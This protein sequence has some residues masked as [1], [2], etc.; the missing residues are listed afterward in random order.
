M[1][2]NRPA[3]RPAPSAPKYLWKGLVVWPDFMS[4]ECHHYIREDPRALADLAEE[5]GT[6]DLSPGSVWEIAGAHA[7]NVTRVFLRSEWYD[8]AGL[9]VPDAVAAHGSSA[10]HYFRRSQWAFPTLEGFKAC[11]NYAED[12]ARR[13]DAR[14]FL[15]PPEVFERFQDDRRGPAMLSSQQD[16]AWTHLRA[17]WRRHRTRFEAIADRHAERL[18]YFR[19]PRKTLTDVWARGPVRVPAGVPRHSCAKH[20]EHLATLVETSSR[21]GERVL[22][23]FGGSAP[24]LRA[25]AMLARSCDTIEQDPAWHRHAARIIGGEAILTDAT[26]QQPGL[27]F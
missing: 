13:L 27:P 15:V 21:P 23:P 25:C 14:P 7:D 6:G 17:Q 10:D 9:R 22:E 26:S 8:R 2:R 19:L 12:H 5:L 24:V 3:L 20:V 1:P 18:P 16:A 4:E 11:A